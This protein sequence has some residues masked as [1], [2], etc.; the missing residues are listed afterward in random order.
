M[1]GKN[2]LG[3]Q[4]PWRLFQ[5]RAGF[6]VSGA[7]AGTVLGGSLGGSSQRAG[8]PSLWGL[9]LLNPFPA[10]WCW[11]SGV[12]RRKEAVRK[13]AC[14]PP[15]WGVLLPGPWAVSPAIPAS[16]PSLPPLPPCHPCLPAG[17][18]LLGL[19]D[20]APCPPQLQPACISQ[21][22]SSLTEGWLFITG[23]VLEASNNNYYLGLLH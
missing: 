8:T 6:G 13:R 11:L 20:A 1:E 16:L 21:E 5:R 17:R 10:P 23:L 22:P 4:R 19:P 15:G 2:V 18:V 12:W 7:T 9:F 3:L 14:V